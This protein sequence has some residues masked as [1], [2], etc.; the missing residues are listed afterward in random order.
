[1]LC[2]QLSSV[3]SCPLRYRR[4]LQLRQ[5]DVLSKKSRRPVLSSHVST[6]VLQWIDAVVR[7]TGV[8]RRPASSSSAHAPWE[9]EKARSAGEAFKSRPGILL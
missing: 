6:T 4:D 3:R 2:L 9:A 5:R 7:E 8:I 1:M